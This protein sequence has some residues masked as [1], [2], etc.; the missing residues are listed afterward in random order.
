MNTLNYYRNVR[1]SQ[2]AENG[3][4]IDVLSFS[5]ENC[6]HLVQGRL[7]RQLL[8]YKVETKIH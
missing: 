6:Q 3:D 8:M 5:L 2:F 4:G 7:T 1:S